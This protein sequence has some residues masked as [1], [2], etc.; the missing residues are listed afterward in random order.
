MKNK[1]QKKLTQQ[2]EKLF[3]RNFNGIG[4]SK[5]KGS[6][7]LHG[8][9]TLREQIRIVGKA[10]SD[11]N[12]TNLKQLTPFMAQHYLNQCRDNGLSQKYLS[13]IKCSL[14]RALFKHENSKLTR[15]IATPRKTVP[16]TDKNRAYTHAQIKMIMGNMD[17][18]AKLSTLIA[19][20]AGLRVE[21][22]LTIRRTDEAKASDSRVWSEHRFAGREEGIRYIVTGKNGLSREV[23]INKDLAA[24]METKRLSSPKTIQDRKESFTIH[25]ELLGGKRFTDAFYYASN[26]ALGWSHGAHGLRFTYAQNRMDNELAKFPYKEA[27]LILSQELGHFREE[28][29][30]RYLNP[31]AKKN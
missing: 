14:E 17:D 4:K 11:L 5:I 6:T 25:Y 15:V 23:L 26:K 9:R 29:T 2:A 30:D 28:I 13:T 22:L 27:K 20:N 19:V 7:L 10:A 16:L 18:R 21:E 31:Y 3:K 12:I 1:T 8:R 24:L